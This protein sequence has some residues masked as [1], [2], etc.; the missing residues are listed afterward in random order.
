MGR[1]NGGEGREFEGA[2]RD[3]T[4]P[5]LPL[6]ANYGFGN[7]ME[8]DVAEFGRMLPGGAIPLES[9]MSRGCQVEGRA[10]SMYARVRNVNFFLDYF[11]S[12]FF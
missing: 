4:R 2:W 9:G 11:F 6:A 8:A 12:P 7:S 10:C 5:P 1:F 3:A